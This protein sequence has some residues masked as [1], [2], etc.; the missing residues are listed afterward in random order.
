VKIVVPGESSD[1]TLTRTS[2]RRL[3]GELLA[4]GAE[5]YEYQP[6]FRLGTRS[7]LVVLVRPGVFFA[8]I[9]PATSSASSL[10]LLAS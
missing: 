9:T 3:Y 7:A 2:S 6:S 1:H 10:T 4:A 8:V 5:I